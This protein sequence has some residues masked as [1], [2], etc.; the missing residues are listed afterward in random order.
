MD[1]PPSVTA[2]NWAGTFSEKVGRH[3]SVLG[4]ED[5]VEA[6]LCFWPAE[7]ASFSVCVSTHPFFS[8]LPE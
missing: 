4:C 7:C 3:S 5:L 6:G 8:Q 2:A 1:G